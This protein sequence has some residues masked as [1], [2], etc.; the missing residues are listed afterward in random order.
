M[1]EKGSRMMFGMRLLSYKGP[2]CKLGPW[3]AAGNLDFGNVPT[4]PN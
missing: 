3:L 1:A 4:F 2:A